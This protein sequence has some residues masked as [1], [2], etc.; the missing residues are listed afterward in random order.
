MHAQPSKWFRFNFP[1][2]IHS[3]R[4]AYKRFA[5]PTAAKYIASVDISLAPFVSQAYSNARRNAYF[6]FPLHSLH[7]PVLSLLSSSCLE[8]T[9]PLK[10][11]LA[12]VLSHDHLFHGCGCKLEIIEN[13]SFLLFCRFFHSESFLRDE[14]FKQNSM[15]RPPT[16]DR[17]RASVFYNVLKSKQPI[18]KLP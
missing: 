9:H 6:Y 16:S 13:W 14:N 4:L 5:P 15:M 18:Q 3:V 17:M 12:N 7:L 8:N 10:S 2:E 11:P 1:V